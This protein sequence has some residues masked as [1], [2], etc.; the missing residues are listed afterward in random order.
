MSKSIM[1]VRDCTLLWT[2]LCP[3]CVRGRHVI[4]ANR[5]Y[6]RS[7]H[8]H[9][10]FPTCTIRDEVKAVPLDYASYQIH[11]GQLNQ[12]IETL[13][14]GRVLLWSEMR[15]LRTSVNQ[16][17]LA[18]SH[19][20]GKFSV[21]SRE[22]ETI[23][24]AFSPNIHVD[25]GDNVL[26]GMDPYSQ[27]VM[28]QYQLLDDRKKL[29][30]QIQALPG[31]DTFLR[32]P[33]LD[34]LRSAACHGPV[35]IINHSMWRSDILVLHDSHPSLITMPDDFFDRANKLQD[36]LLWE[37]KKGLDSEKYE[38]ALRSVLQELYELIGRPVIQ[39][40]IEL[41]V[42]EQSRVRWCPTPVFCSL[43]LHAM[44][45]IPSNGGTLRYFPDLYDP[46]YTTSLFSLIGSRKPG[47]QTLNKPSILLVVQPDENMPNALKEMKAIQATNTQVTI[48]FSPKATPTAVLAHLRDHRFAHI[49][50]HGILEPGK[51]FEASFKLHRGKRLL[52]LDIVR[53]Q[54]PD[55]EFAFL[56]AGH[57]AELTDKSIADEVLHLVAAMQFCGFRSVVGTMW[58]MADIDGRDLARDFYKSVFSD[59]TQGHYYERTAAAL[60]DAVVRLRRK[61][62]MTLERWVNFVHYGA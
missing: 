51:P 21:L 3:N 11:A 42:P 28:R 50:S 9:T 6:I 25:G 26:E 48:A 61:R 34:T 52:L 58:A 13:E 12:A 30:S 57:T 33:S 29:I 22:L 17:A 23:T 59:G 38:D 18:D 45:P 24:L 10:A 2:S 49:V 43:P 5:S 16:L 32:P 14:Q 53:S 35:I 39:R 46:S 36:Q 44:G 1:V 27:L 60:R 7:N 56:S 47:A 62:G 15:G 31:F 20:A 19:L 41:N 8:R 4:D 40:L 37:R 55:A 54:L